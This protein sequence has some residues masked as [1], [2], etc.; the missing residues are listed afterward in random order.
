[1][2]R[3]RIELCCKALDVAFCDLDLTAFEG[4]AELGHQTTQYLPLI[5]SP[6]N[7]PNAT[8]VGSVGADRIEIAH[9]GS[10]ISPVYRHIPRMRAPMSTFGPWLAG[11]A[12]VP[13]GASGQAVR[14]NR[15]SSFSGM[16]R[17]LEA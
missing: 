6:T 8:R 16:K 17:V 2:H 12:A 4:R 5:L 13:A 7:S 3:L 10:L 9:G 11:R 14:S 15:S 1:M